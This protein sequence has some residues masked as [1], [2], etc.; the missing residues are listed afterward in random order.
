MSAQLRP[1]KPSDLSLIRAFHGEL[2]E[3]SVYQRFFEF[4]ALDKRV[5]SERLTRI[6][7]TDYDR[8]ITLVA[9]LEVD[10][11]KEIIGVGKLQ[12]RL[13]PHTADIKLIIVDKYHHLGLGSAI[14]IK[15]IE[16]AKHEKVS[17]LEALV[18]NENET[19]INLCQKFNFKI[20]DA[21]K[22]VKKLNL[23]L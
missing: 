5:A 19:M 22:G 15:L 21:G 2:S 3:N 18:L 17:K 4:I 14:L 13:E 1:I 9:E 6:C 7:F 12:K 10:G 8:E 11:H 20:S 16:V 23:T